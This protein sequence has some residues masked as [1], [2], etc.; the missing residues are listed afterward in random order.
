MFDFLKNL[1]LETIGNVITVFNPVAGIVVKSIDAVVN[2]DN[3]SISNDSVI[4]V[5]ESMSKSKGNDADTELV[6]LIAL[7]LENKGK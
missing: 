7:Y 6:D 1:D 4:K 2:S 3:E 5:V